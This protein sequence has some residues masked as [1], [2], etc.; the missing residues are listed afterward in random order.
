[1]DIKVNLAEVQSAIS[2]IIT[3]VESSRSETAGTYAR[4]ISGFS[5]SSGK[6]AEALRELSFREQEMAVAISETLIQFAKSVQFA[7]EQLDELDGTGA[8]SMY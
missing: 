8:K 2:S 1:M 6:E 4:L 3:K 7:A 5:E